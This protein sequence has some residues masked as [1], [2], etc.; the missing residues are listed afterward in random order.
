MPSPLQYPGVDLTREAEWSVTPAPT[1]YETPSGPPSWNQ[2]SVETSQSPSL[3]RADPI[4]TGDAAIVEVWLQPQWLATH[5][6]VSFMCNVLR[7]F[8]KLSPKYS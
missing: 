3:P 4:Q 7:E 2:H 1:S 8:R 5:L 6:A